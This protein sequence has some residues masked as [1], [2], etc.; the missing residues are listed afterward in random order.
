MKVLLSKFR[1][2]ITAMI[3]VFT[4]AS[5]RKNQGIQHK[6]AFSRNREK[7]HCLPYDDSC[8]NCPNSEFEKLE[9]RLSICKHRQE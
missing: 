2:F 1:S 3:Y 7:Q 5:S 8:E 4:C 6:R 9:A